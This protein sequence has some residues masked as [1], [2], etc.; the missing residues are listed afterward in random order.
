ML[1]HSPSSHELTAGGRADGL[2]IIV[3]QLDPLSC[4]L[5]QH[6]GVDVRAMVADVPIALVVHHDED[7]VGGLGPGPRSPRGT[8]AVV[9]GLS[10]MQ[11]AKTAQ[12]CNHNQRRGKADHPAHLRCCCGA[13]LGQVQLDLVKEG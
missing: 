9:Q 2:D 4:Q 7:Q 5:I 1:N 6:W 12:Q 3:L 11:E 10:P 8:S 13:C